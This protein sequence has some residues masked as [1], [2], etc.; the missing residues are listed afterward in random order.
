MTRHIS[1]S[2]LVSCRLVIK[3]MRLEVEP[4]RRYIATERALATVSGSVTAAMHV[5]ECSITKHCTT[6]TRKHRLTLTEV[7]QNLL[8]REVRQKMHKMCIGII[9]AACSGVSHFCVRYLYLP[10]YK[11]TQ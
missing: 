1:V 8:V 5:E 3:E 6:C 2:F 4:V 7:V 11:Y 10:E 9:T